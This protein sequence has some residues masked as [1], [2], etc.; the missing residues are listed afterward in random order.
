VTT[1]PCR[2]A[3][4]RSKFTGAEIQAAR[5]EEPLTV[6]LIFYAPKIAYWAIFLTY[7]ITLL[8]LYASLFALQAIY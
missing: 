4:T 5:F 2:L 8:I 1:L 3:T 7:S 6:A